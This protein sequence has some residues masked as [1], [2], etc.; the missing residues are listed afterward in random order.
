MKFSKS[1]LIL[2][3]LVLLI[4]MGDPTN[5]ITVK[6]QEY[7]IT[8]NFDES[9]RINNFQRT[10]VDDE[11]NLIISG[12]TGDVGDSQNDIIIMKYSPKGSL[13][14]NLELGG[15]GIDQLLLTDLHPDGLI[16]LY[17]QTNSPDFPTSQGAY[18]T[19][20]GGGELDSFVT[21]LSN[22]GQIEWS[23]YIGGSS[24][25]FNTMKASRLNK[26]QK[27]TFDNDGN[28]IAF[29]ETT[30]IDF[31]IKKAEYD[32]YSGNSDGYMVKFTSNGSVIW[33]SYLGGN[34]GDEG[35]NDYYLQQDGSVHFFG[36]T[37]SS[38]LKTVGNSFQSDY[39]GST[40]NRYFGKFDPSG[41][42]VWS[43]YFG[44]D[45]DIP[46]I[47]VGTYDA[48]D[49]HVFITSTTNDNFPVTDNSTHKGNRDLILS[50][51]DNDGNRLWST[52]FGG[53]ENDFPHYLY[54]N[55]NPPRILIDNSE[56]I[57][58]MY[59]TSSDDIPLINAFQQEKIQG[60]YQAYIV[61]YSSDGDLIFSSY[62]AK[63]NRIPLHDVLN[64][65]SMQIDSNNNLIF[66]GEISTNELY[67]VNAHQTNFGGIRDIYIRKL[68]PN[69]DV[70]WSSYLGGS[71]IEELIDTRIDEFDNYYL[72]GDTSSSDLP[73][74]TIKGDS[75]LLLVKFDKYGEQQWQVA[76]GGQGDEDMVNGP[77]DE[78]NTLNIHPDGSLLV[79]GTTTSKD[80]F[81][82]ESDDPDFRHVWPFVTKIDKNGE[83]Q[84]MRYIGVEETQI[85][86]ESPN[87]RLILFLS[88]SIL[89]IG[90]GWH[91]GRT[92]LASRNEQNPLGKVENSYIVLGDNFPPE[93]LKEKFL[94]HP[95]RLA[96]FKILTNNIQM[97]SSELRLR[98]GI[99]WGDYSSHTK[100][101]TKTGYIRLEDKMIDGL[102]KQVISL[103]LSGITKYRY[104]VGL[105][106]EYLDESI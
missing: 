44:D 71:G 17:G 16:I 15:S 24:L 67:P 7:Y 54:I 99:S 18:Q 11:G 70:N 80:L 30:S 87:W 4:L 37:S 12:Q 104:L 78:L 14:W 66:S 47:S 2:T 13:L 64:Q 45:S 43:T 90:I 59:Y 98:L 50:K 3:M 25:D 21:V 68:E 48:H 103:E 22:N 53:S 61:K 100:A 8:S 60:K 82:V 27:T 38:N 105:I 10:I 39:R 95:V 85:I 46:Y 52:Q 49:N 72:L 75:D 28:F 101:L 88:S 26:H 77:E 56:E 79:I 83:I 86:L 94:L 73:G 41:K 91:Y 5:S 57:V 63:F 93:L 29:G 58:F 34:S 89:L 76:V 97:S 20:Y 23:T 74:L 1:M 96:I 55:G 36:Q 102:K 69:G 6:G 31:P 84:W 9:K 35:F 40:S 33:S 42:L 106:S 81:R 32:L 92:I 51:F 62:I 19:E 65:R